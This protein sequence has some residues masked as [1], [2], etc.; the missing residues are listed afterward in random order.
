[1]TF[2]KTGHTMYYQDRAFRSLASNEPR[3]NYYDIATGAEYWISRPKRDG[4][5][6][7]DDDAAPAEIDADV[8]EEYWTKVR[9]RPDRVT[10]TV[11]TP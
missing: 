3:P 11:A 4:F 6:H 8:L 1:V 2:S 5:D 10:E 7:L 9:G